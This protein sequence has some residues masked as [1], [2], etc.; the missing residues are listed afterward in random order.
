FFSGPVAHLAGRADIVRNEARPP[1]AGRA[2]SRAAPQKL[3]VGRLLDVDWNHT[4]ACI[5]LDLFVL[6]GDG[7]S[8]R[9]GRPVA[10][11]A[12]PA[13]EFVLRLD[14][15]DTDFLPDEPDVDSQCL[16]AVRPSG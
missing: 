15:C 7:G 8:V 11:L 6:A 10:L 1:A 14:G 9:R 16:S 12:F 4:A 13:L 5:W 2:A 3:A